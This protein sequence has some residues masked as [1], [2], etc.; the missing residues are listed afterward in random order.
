MPRGKVWRK[1]SAKA[2]GDEQEPDTRCGTHRTRGHVTSNEG[3]NRR[4]ENTRQEDVNSQPIRQ[5]WLP[6]AVKGELGTCDL[7][8]ENPT[9]TWELME[10]IVAPEN[11]RAAYNRVTEIAK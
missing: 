4:R 10:W 2:R 5:L 1:P 11:L 7:S 9:E 8:A 3:R 6:L